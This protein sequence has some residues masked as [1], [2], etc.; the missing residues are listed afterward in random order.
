MQ[1]LTT[2]LLLSCLRTAWL[3]PEH[4]D[5]YSEQLITFADVVERAQRMGMQRFPAEAAVFIDFLSLPQ[6][7]AHGE[8]TPAELRCFSE[9]LQSMQMWYCHALTFVVLLSQLPKGAR[10]EALTS[11]HG[12]GWCT[13]E[14]SW[15]RLAKHHSR[16]SWHMVLDAGAP[17]AALS[18]AR[19]PPMAP[20]AMAELVAS[21]RFTSAK[22][23]LPKVIELN[24]KTM[25]CIFHE[26]TTLNYADCG[27]GADEAVQFAEVLPFCKALESL[28]LV[29]NSIGDRGAEAIGRWLP[30]TTTLKTL[31]LISNEIGVQGAAALAEGLKRNSSVETVY[32]GMNRLGKDGVHALQ[33][34]ME[35][36]G[37]TLTVKFH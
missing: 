20:E 7:D 28:L 22:A 24:V 15:A 13:C 10:W 32:L 6:K 29:R 37:S 30:S 5:P 16:A 18:V 35:A 9:A 26:V 21:K 4:P 8:R 36:R 17:S 1:D 19:P 11:Y 23:D 2:A 34:A 31:G 3:T 25:C 33:E 27:W 12:R 14:S